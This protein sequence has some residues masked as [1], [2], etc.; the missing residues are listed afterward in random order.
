MVTHQ[1]LAKLCEKSYGK[2]TISRH[3]VEISINKIDGVWFCAIRGTQTDGI[4]RETIKDVLRNVFAS[5]WYMEGI[6][7]HAGM[8]LGAKAIVGELTDYLPAGC[9]VW[10]TGHSQ[11]GGIAIPLARLLVVRGYNV[12]GVTTFGCPLVLSFGRNLY[13]NI[14]VHQY[15]YR[16]DIVPVLMKGL[17]FRKHINRVLLGPA[18]SKRWRDRTWDDHSISLYIEALK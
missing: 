9:P 10:L 11:G 17:L 7:G 5:G 4:N 6:A 13:E 16:N 3:G 1:E 12:A 18:R 2:C 14:K 8:L 15:E